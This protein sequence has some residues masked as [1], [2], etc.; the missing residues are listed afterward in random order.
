MAKTVAPGKI[1]IP[2]IDTF[3]ANALPDPFDERDLEYRPRLEP[4]PSVL[5]QRTGFDKNYVMR[6]FGSSCTGHAL[7]AVINTVLSRGSMDGGHDR[8][9]QA[10]HVSPY[11]LY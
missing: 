11:M 9:A 10:P 8:P 4:L 6:Q 7:A 5:D 2:H 3:I 1:D